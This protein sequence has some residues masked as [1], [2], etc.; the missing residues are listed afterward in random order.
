MIIKDVEGTNAIFLQSGLFYLLIAGVESDLHV[1]TLIDK[2]TI[3]G[4]T[5]NEGSACCRG[6]YLHNTHH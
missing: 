5:L 2:H 4:T 1:I 6:L 3:G